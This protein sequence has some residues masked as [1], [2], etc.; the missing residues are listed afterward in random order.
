VPTD[1]AIRLLE[2]MR[3]NLSGWTIYDLKYLYNGFEFSIRHGR[4]HDI[5]K[6]PQYPILRATIPRKHSSGLAKGYI[7][8]AV[9]LIDQLERLQKGDKK[10]GQ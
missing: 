8:H 9:K 7:S 1:D 6:H 10:N 3:R 2:G 4:K 5:V